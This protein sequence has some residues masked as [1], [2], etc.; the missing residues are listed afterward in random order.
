M[1]GFLSVY[2]LIQ[3]LPQ[4]LL[5]NIASTGGNVA[6]RDFVLACAVAGRKT[7]KAAVVTL[8]VILLVTLGG[9]TYLTG[10]E[11]ARKAATELGETSPP[12]T[13]DDKQG[14]DNLVILPSLDWGIGDGH[15]F[16]Q[17]NGRSRGTSATGFAV[18]NRDGVLFWEKF[19]ELGG[20]PALGYPLSRRFDW[21]GRP[22]QVF[23]RGVLQWDSA[24]KQVLLVNILDELSNSGKDDWLKQKHDTPNPLPANFD[25]GKSWER[26]VEDRLSLLSSSTAI[27]EHYTSK[28]DS[29]ELYGLPT[30][31]AED[32]GKHM[33]VR[34]QRAVIREWKEDPRGV[35][36]GYLVVEH[37][38]EWAIEAGLFPPEALVPEPAPEP[39]DSKPV[40]Q[41]EPEAPDT[42]PPTPAAPSSPPEDVVVPKR[43]LVGNTGKMGVYIRR[44]PHMDDKIVA[45][46]DHTV[47]QAT[48]KTAWSEERSWVQVVDP[49]GNR[50][51]VPAQYLLTDAQ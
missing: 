4:R 31:G 23:H 5:P 1:K 45:W 21:T 49:A 39:Q 9:C 16:T 8:S 43:M 3:H 14:E 40:A 34:F 28:P 2:R 26:I 20:V 29:L 37:V 25:A 24:S 32:F 38:G 13:T 50:G 10:N 33:T 51:W 41:Q 17:T 48:G 44:T 36:A 11:T 7:S 27:G 15:F 18:T 35:N 19:R 12:I 46:P 6:H 30:S 47:M 22:T 42:A